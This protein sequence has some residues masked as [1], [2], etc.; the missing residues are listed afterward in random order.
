M[1]FFQ[2]EEKYFSGGL[3]TNSNKKFTKFT[4]KLSKGNEIKLQNI[5]KAFELRF[6]LNTLWVSENN[7]FAIWQFLRWNISKF[8]NYKSLF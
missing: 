4:K 3:K 1:I 5:F 8:V 2:L 7:P 6:F